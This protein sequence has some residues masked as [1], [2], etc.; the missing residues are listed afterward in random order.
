MGTMRLIRSRLSWRFPLG[1]LVLLS[2]V[3]PLAGAGIAQTASTSQRIAFSIYT[4]STSG[5]YFPTGERIATLIS[6]PPGVGRCETLYACGPMGLIATARASQGSIANIRAVESG[7]ASS[8]FTQAD[9]LA[10]A[11]AGSGVFRAQG[12]VKHVRVIAQ[13]YPEA[14]H[15]VAAAKAPILSVADLKGKRV[16]LLN[17]ESGTLDTARA[18]LAAYGLSE[19][20]IKPN[21]DG[22]DQAAELLQEGKLDAFFFVGGAPSPIISQLL[23]QGGGVLIPIEG[24]GRKQLLARESY[25]SSYVI[26]SGTY[27][28]SPRVETVSTG[29]LWI[30]SDTQPDDRIYGIVRALYNPSNRSLLDTLG[31]VGRL[32]QP[33]IAAQTKAA[34][35]HPGAQRFYQESNLLPQL[36]NVPVPKLSPRRS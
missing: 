20:S 9:T 30:T 23:E 22:V 12:A 24:K 36:K 8:G 29:A 6:H 27:S 31:A 28:G 17:A 16:S 7:Y 4:G 10:R 21:Y 26:P 11:T 13:L 2:F 33:A 34:P 14:V 35:F 18:V 5:T 15:L 19:R 32:I 1:L 25:L 3:A